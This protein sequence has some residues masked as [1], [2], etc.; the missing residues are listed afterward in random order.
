[1]SRPLMHTFR[2]GGSEVAGVLYLH[3]RDQV[4]VP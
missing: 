4:R 1:M 2:T 3:H